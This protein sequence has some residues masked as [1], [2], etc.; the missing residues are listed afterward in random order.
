MIS[1]EL[2]NQIRERDKGRCQECGL[3]VGKDAGFEGNVHHI[4]PKSN[5]GRDEIG[6]LAYAGFRLNP[7]HFP[8]RDIAASIENTISALKALKPFL[9]DIATDG[10]L[11]EPPDLKEVVESIRIA[12]HGHDTQPSLDQIILDSQSHPP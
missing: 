12:H 4:I 2:R 5:G 3:K 6:N 8:R 7:K 9:D 10:K 1:Q 11:L